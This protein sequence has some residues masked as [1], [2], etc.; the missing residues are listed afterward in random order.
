MVEVLKHLVG[1]CGDGHV[2]IWHIL[3]YGATT[4]GIFW[5]YIRHTIQYCWKKGC[6]MCKSKLF[7]GEKVNN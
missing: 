7:R 6:K 1:A 2:T 3:G 4:I 5:Y